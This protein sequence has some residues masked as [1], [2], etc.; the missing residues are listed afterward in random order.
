MSF[1]TEKS[2]IEALEDVAE[3]LH[4]DANHQK[5]VMN[6]ISK[7]TQKTFKLAKSYK[8]LHGTK[9][10]SAYITWNDLLNLPEY[11]T[12]FGQYALDCSS[13]GLQI[14][15]MLLK[16]KKLATCCNLTLNQGKSTNIYQE[17]ADFLHRDVFNFLSEFLEESEK[18]IPSLKTFAAQEFCQKDSQEIYNDKTFIKIIKKYSKMR[19]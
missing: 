15:S 12:T 5:L 3:N 14:M 13:S 10:F 11:L 2:N 16:S 6:D 4:N 8:D 17:F 19:K 7:Y 18:L 9:M 1:E